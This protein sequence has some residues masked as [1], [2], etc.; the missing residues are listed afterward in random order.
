MARKLT[1]FTGSTTA[2]LIALG[3]VILWALLGP[4]FGY[5]ETW[6]LV[7]NTATTIVTFLMVFLIQRAQ[8]KDSLAIQ[9][10]LD[11]LVA[12]HYGASNRLVAAEELSERDLELLRRDYRKLM[13]AAQREEDVRGAHSV[14]EH[15]G[16]QA[17]RDDA[18]SAAGGEGSGK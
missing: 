17:S 1:D 4:V 10:K 6:Q 15:R 8:N 13:R 7:I 3:S 11:E 9:L 5:S 16:R 2:F 14:D 18:G 12:A